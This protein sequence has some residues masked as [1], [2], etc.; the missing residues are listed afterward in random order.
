MCFAH[1]PHIAKSAMYGAP[2]FVGF[3]GFCLYEEAD[4]FALLREDKGR[5]GGS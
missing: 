2:G 4:L 5:V 1:N 3:L